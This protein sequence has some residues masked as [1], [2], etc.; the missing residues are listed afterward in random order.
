MDRKHGASNSMAS[1]DAGRSRFH[2]RTTYRFI[3]TPQIQTSILLAKLID[4]SPATGAVDL[5]LASRTP[6]TAVI[7]SAFAYC[8]R[9]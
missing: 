6:S 3:L 8:A 5:G 1:C 2:R 7:Q 9:R 4:E